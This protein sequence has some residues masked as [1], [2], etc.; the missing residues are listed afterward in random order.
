MKAQ[1]ET[2]MGAVPPKF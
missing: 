1:P 2:L